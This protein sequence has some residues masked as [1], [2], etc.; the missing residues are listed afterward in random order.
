MADI[1]NR[2]YCEIDGEVIEAN[3]IDEKISGNK[4][5]VRAMNRRNRGIGHHHGVPEFAITL[6]FTADHDLQTRF[7]K[8]LTDNT[9]FSV[10]VEAE[11]ESGVSKTTNYVDCEVY[12]VG[13]SGKEGAAQEFTVDITALDRSEC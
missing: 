3:S 10:V 6:T 4:E 1:V 8:L 11:G 9:Q 12:E 5:V 13:K 7:V 2:V